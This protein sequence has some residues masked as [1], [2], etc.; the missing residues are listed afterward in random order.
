MQ[1]NTLVCGIKVK[2]QALL[3]C[4][5]IALAFA[6][7]NASAVWQPGLLGG[8]HT[9]GAAV[10]ATPPARTNVFMDCHAATNYISSSSAHSNWTPIW[11]SNR[12]WQYWGQV[13]LPAGTH[14]FGAKIDDN[15]QLIIGG[16][17][18]ITQSG[19]S[20]KTATFTAA[21]DGWYDFSFK[22]GNGTGGAGPYGNSGVGVK[23]NNCPIGFGVKWNGAG[24]YQWLA[25]DGTMSR[26]RHDDGNGFPDE[27]TFTAEPFEVAVPGV[28]YAT[29]SGLAAGG[30]TFSVPSGATVFADGS[31]ATC[32]GWRLYSIDTAT[33]ATTL[34]ASGDTASV[35]FEHAAG[36]CWHVVWLWQVEYRVT[37]T[38]N[39][40]G[41]VAPAEQWVVR[42]GT[43]TVTATPDAAHGFYRWTGDVPASVSPTAATLTIPI[44][45]PAAVTAS[46][47][48]IL[49][50]AKS[51]ND[52]NDGTSWGT[53][54]ATPEKALSIAPHGTTVIVGPG[55][56]ET[57]GEEI[58][59]TNNV[60]FMSSDGAA[61]TTLKAVNP[62]GTKK[63]GTIIKRRVLY[64]NAP[65]AIVEG[66]TMTDGYWYNAGSQNTDYLTTN[67]GGGDLVLK[68]GT[69][70]NC[71]IT[72]VSNGGTYGGG[73]NMSGGTLTNCVI[74]GNNSQYNNKTTGWG[75]GVY[76]SNGLVVDCVITNNSCGQYGSGVCLDGGTLRNCLVAGNKGL[77]RLGVIGAV[78]QNKASVVEKCVVRDNTSYHARA[79]LY[80]N[81]DSAVARNVL[82]SGNSGVYSGQGAYI[83]KG[84]IENC[85]L[86]GNTSQFDTVGAGLYQDAGT[87]VNTIV[88]GGG[89]ADASYIRVASSATF[90]T[91]LT[92][93]AVAT[94]SATVTDNIVGAPRFADAAQDDYTLRFDSPAVG[95]AQPLAS[96]KTDLA[97]VARGASPSIGCYEY[98]PSGAL[99]GGFRLSGTRL[100][101][102]GSA[103]A[104]AIVEGASGAVSYEWYLDG[105]LQGATGPTFAFDAP[106][107]P[108]A[109]ALRLVVTSGGESASYEEAAAFAVLPVVTYA[110][111][112]GSDTFPYDTRE[113]GAHYLQD[114]VDA[115]WC[116]DDAPGTVR[117]APGTY[118]VD[119]IWTKL[120]KAV[121]V[122]S[123]EGPAATILK[124]RNN[125]DPNQLRHVL[126][127]AHEG[128]VVSGFTIRD[129]DWYSLNGGNA[130]G[131]IQMSAGTVTNCVITNNRGGGN[132]DN[133]VGGGGVEL[134]GGTVADCIIRGN[135][136]VYNNNGSTGQ[137][138]GVRMTGGLVH[139]CVISNNWAACNPC[140]SGVWMNNGTLSNCVVAANYVKGNDRQGIGIAMKGGTVTRCHIWG[141]GKYG[142]TDR[143]PGTGGGVFISGGKL[144][145]SLVEDNRVNNAGAGVY[146]TGGTVEFCTVSGNTSTGSGGSGLYLNGSKA[147]ARYNVLYGNGAGVTAEAN[148]NIA[149]TA[150]ASFATNVVAPATSGVDNID[151]DPLLAADY[152][153]ATGSSAID[154]APPEAAPAID[155]AGNARPTDGN[156]DGS[157]LA[158]LGCFEAAD[159]SAG[160]LRC[161]FSPTEVAGH[162][163]VT[164]T[165]TASVSGT[166]SDGQ[167]AYFWDFGESA[168]DVTYAEGGAVAT[169]T[170]A[171]YGTHSVSL[172]VTAGNASA[173][174]EVAECVRVGSRV[175][176]LK[177]DNAT[178]AWPYNTQETA[179]TDAVEA[180][181]TAVLVDGVQQE[182]IVHAGT[183]P[184]TEQWIALASPTWV[185][186]V[187]GVANCIFTAAYPT[188]NQRRL[189]HV[190]HESAVIE[191]VTLANGYWNGNSFGNSGCTRISAGAISN[192]VIR[193]CIGGNTAGQ[194]EIRGGEVVGCVIR[195]GGSKA[196]GN[197]S[198]GRGGGVGIL[199]PGRLISCVV[200]NNYAWETVDGYS[201]GGVCMTDSGAV[202]RDCLIANNH[203]QYGLTDTREDTRHGGGIAMTAGLVENC[204]IRDNVAYGNYGGIYQMGGTVR[205][206][207]VDGNWSPK[208]DNQG[209]GVT[210]AS[211]SFVNNTVVT[212]GCADRPA[213]IGA[214]LA[215]GTVRNS[216]FWGTVG[217]DASQGGATVANC[218]FGG[219][220]PFR[221]PARG[222]WRLR[223]GSPCIGAGDWTALGASPEA[224]R[225]MRDLGGQPRLFG[226]QVDIG[227]F[228]KAIRRTMTAVR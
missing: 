186:G 20:L 143:V 128:A 89:E 209:V 51:G 105:V 23:T 151:D 161:S 90:R 52:G 221:N 5:A 58:R 103:T 119:G 158:D 160:P 190:N 220:S 110:N 205:N 154:R 50:V 74:R 97:D 166:G 213:G 11:S 84:R 123:E 223:S 40:G 29:V 66:F 46:F 222:D 56:Y 71:V 150:A 192:C 80:L 36:D 102:S 38:A 112:N 86:V 147:V 59:V 178:P 16:T 47:G 3:A 60:T 210:A 53:A 94:S 26:F 212:N 65:N 115:C 227:C 168:T 21:E 54:F 165:F 202:V 176:H 19:N 34:S 163:S 187:D 6:A 125:A 129:A 116:A 120:M 144:V 153:L 226:G 169:A 18:L 219:A 142:T 63:N 13:F 8:F 10:Y 73:V 12:C 133:V 39:A 173:D 199:G 155:L 76:M 216:V 132:G 136:S 185:H 70:R 183:Y 172:T 145:N 139:G 156:G 100:G 180:F 198:K 170:F 98:V 30:Q 14:T 194:L 217:S 43:A 138:G 82:V 96:V 157:A 224:V 77:Q 196:D 140:G 24:N 33:G 159:A 203:A 49:Y 81:H 106:A 134:S 62:N 41:S 57:V 64:V 181:S 117:V 32:L 197:N 95:A 149:F 15:S 91:N 28:S 130:P 207:L 141:N 206:C 87:V 189:F 191:G 108:G 135:W 4:V 101:P 200:T 122:I 182:Y 79:G 148:C 67:I 27:I 204:I 55:T 211:A 228:E 118:P 215:A 174:S 7:P 126:Y 175:I 124:A 72:G 184:I 188:T 31:R 1:S 214:N 121:R 92:D 113:K 22:C 44:T 35:A 88:T 104:T 17:T 179:A 42:G 99:N 9:A 201:G 111:A 37:A 225:A 78:F 25:D 45:A 218:L 83:A 75:G 109:H 93:A 137:G 146:Q 127:I 164:A 107:T 114:A 208:K 68:N 131:A 152:T 171:A 61:S 167:L 85:T 2:S 48:S 162:D 195:N 193:N 177:A 69:V